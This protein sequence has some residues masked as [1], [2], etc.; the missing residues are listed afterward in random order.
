MILLYY[1]V[2]SYN[3]SYYS[4]LNWLLF[5]G[6]FLIKNTSQYCKSHQ[7]TFMDYKFYASREDFMLLNRRK[8]KGEKRDFIYF[9][10]FWS[11]TE[12]Q[13]STSE[14]PWSTTGVQVKY[15]WNNVRYDWS[16]VKY[17]WSTHSWSL[18]FSP[19]R[20]SPSWFWPKNT[21]RLHLSWIVSV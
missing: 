12:V 4:Y 21:H 7:Y 14:I 10:I 15:G 17:K 5:F 1:R 19:L 20:K 6:F 9:E 2:W 16:N 18:A 11:T 8:S 13:W 3:L